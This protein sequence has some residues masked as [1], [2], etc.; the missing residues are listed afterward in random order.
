MK[1]LKKT[2]RLAGAGYLVIF[3]TG[4]FANFFVLEGL[5]VEGNAQATSENIL[6]NLMQFRWGIFAF[7]IMVVIDVLMA[8]PLYILLKSVNKN[9]SLLSAWLRLVNGTIFGV[10]LYSLFGILHLLSGAEYLSALEPAEIHARVMLHLEAFNFIW[11]I[12]LVFF[13]LHLF[14][15]GILILKSDYIPK[16]IGGLLQLAAVGYLTDSFAQ[17]LLPDYKSVQH[18][19]ELVVLI[20]GV[21]GELSFTVWLLIKGAK[22]KNT[23]IK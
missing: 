11:L 1:A 22:T 20:P 5:V 10:A 23:T 21:I 16:I 14:L 6:A 12:G 13:G 9:L 15:M 17:F 4:F 19:F 2:A 7:L 8:G 3:I 18:V